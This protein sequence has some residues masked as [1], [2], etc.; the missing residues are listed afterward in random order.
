[1]TSTPESTDLLDSAQAAGLVAAR[2]VAEGAVDVRGGAVLLHGRVIA[3]AHRGT[4]A[5]R[6]LSCLRL[7]AETG[8]VPEVLRGSQAT[9]GPV[10]WTEAVRGLRLSELTGTM[11]ELAEVCQAWGTALATLHLTR[12]GTAAEAPAARRPWVLNP[13]RLPRGMRQAPAGSARA[14]VLRTLCTDRGLVRT[15]SRVADRWTADRWTHGDVTADRVLVLRRPDLT[16]RFVDLR[17]GGLGDPG[18][19]L[20]AALETVE[21]LTAG[22]RARWRS[23]NG[24]C[25]RDY[26]LRGYRRTGGVAVVDA[27][28]TALRIVAQAWELAVGLDARAGHPATMHPSSGHAA[29]ATRLTERLAQARELA[30]RSARPGLVAA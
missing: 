19:D 4:D 13:D 18:W 16:V 30:A 3:Y 21:E 6:E 10:V 15:S 17:A 11:A 20:A 23:T 5:A 28:A 14:Y 9:A 8:L 24:S 25:L 27:G 1:M 22:P 7:L 26:L 2:E 29:E 12:I